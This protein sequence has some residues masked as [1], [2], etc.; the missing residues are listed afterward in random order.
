MILITNYKPPN[1][2]ETFWIIKIEWGYSTSSS[3]V[4][5]YMFDNYDNYG[6]YDKQSF[7]KTFEL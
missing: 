3:L 2:T 5:P 7:S 1:P 4:V 6:Y